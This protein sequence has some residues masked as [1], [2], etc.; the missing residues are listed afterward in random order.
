MKIYI[1]IDVPEITD[2]DE[3]YECGIIDKIIDQVEPIATH[4]WW[5]EIGT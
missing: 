4:D 1:V 3:A 2:R 5:V